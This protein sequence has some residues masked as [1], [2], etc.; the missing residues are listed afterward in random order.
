MCTFVITW[1]LFPRREDQTMLTVEDMYLLHALRTKIQTN[2]TFVI[3][4]HM[5]KVVRQKKYYL[6]YAVFISRIMRFHDVD[7]TNE[8]TI[9]CNK[10]DVI[11][12]LFL[13]HIDKFKPLKRFEKFV[14]ERFSRLDDK[15]SMLQ[16]SFTELHRE[17]DYALRINAFGD[18]SIDDSESEKNC[19][20]EKI[21]KSSESE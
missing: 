15:M 12:K 19:A 17:M 14:V 9:C 2:W 6:P 8:V 5:I 4:D 7:I 10:K 11:E 13:D 21:V 18:T 1:I 16:R 3:N 20:N